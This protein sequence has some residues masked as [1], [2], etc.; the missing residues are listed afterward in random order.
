M[1][2]TDYYMPCNNHNLFACLINNPNLTILTLYLVQ[3]V[4]KVT[5]VVNLKLV[6]TD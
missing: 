4:F 3:K 2:L 5:H 6:F 1:D